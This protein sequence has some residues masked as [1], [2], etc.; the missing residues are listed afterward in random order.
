MNL[1]SDDEYYDLDLIN[2]TRN[3]F[4]NEFNPNLD[5]VAKRIFQMKLHVF[6]QKRPMLPPKFMMDNFEGL[7]RRFSPAGALDKSSLRGRKLIRD[8]AS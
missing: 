6:N 2:K 8:V 3:D 4:V 1:L 5:E 7:V